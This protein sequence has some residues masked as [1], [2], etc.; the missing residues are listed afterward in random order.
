MVDLQSTDLKISDNRKTRKKLI[1]QR[2]KLDREMENLRLNEVELEQKLKEQTRRS[3]IMEHELKDFEEK[4]KKEQAKL[5]K[6]TNAKEM[7]AVQQE[8]ENVI[9]SKQK[10]EEDIF[11]LLLTL[12]DM[13]VSLKQVRE[14]NKAGTE[15]INK[16][17]TANGSKKNSVEQ[18]FVE[19]GE[20]RMARAALL[21]EKYLT[22][23]ENLRKEK[24]GKAIVVVTDYCCKG[25][26]LDL[27]KG[28]I[29]EIRKNAKFT[30]C[31][32]CGRLLYWDGED[33]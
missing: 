30:R 20:E 18:K 11:N 28:T 5:L 16:Q 32:N 19:L 2:E 21:E 31:I 9:N 10:H 3:K 14:S 6:V 26:Y 7:M 8:L 17:I 25:C 4:F 1:M 29:N 15:E 22:M 24:G 23:Y 33:Q 12:E 13:Q 27:P